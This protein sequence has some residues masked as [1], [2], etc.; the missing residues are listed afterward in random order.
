[1]Q[2]MMTGHVACD[3]SKK[4]RSFC[5]FASCLVLFEIW[6]MGIIPGINADDSMIIIK[7]NIH[8][9]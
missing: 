8:W 7:E 3:S 4:G 9:K 2:K 6:S 5:I 1:M